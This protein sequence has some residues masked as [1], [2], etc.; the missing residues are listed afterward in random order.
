MSVDSSTCITELAIKGCF[1]YQ[2]IE[3]QKFWL[4]ENN[5]NCSSN[6]YLPMYMYF[7]TDTCIRHFVPIS[8]CYIIGLYKKIGRLGCIGNDP[9]LQYTSDC[10]LIP[11]N[12]VTVEIHNLFW[13][14]CVTL[15]CIYSSSPEQKS[16]LWAARNYHMYLTNMY[17]NPYQ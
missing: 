16:Q 9:F 2:S 7:I 15:F 10:C 11:L 3:R 12:H 17:E 13:F 8:T 14:M 1:G 6:I 5:H 4:I